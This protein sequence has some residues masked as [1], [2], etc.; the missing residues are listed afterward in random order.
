M[1]GGR[2]RTDQRTQRA[3]H[4]HNAGDVSL[5][6]D[7]DGDT[8]AD[9]VRH[10]VGLQ[11]REGENE[12]RLE[13]QDFRNVR[14]N[15]RRYPRLLA[16]DPRRPYRVAGDANDPILL[17]QKVQRFHSLFGETDDPARRELAHA[18]RMQNYRLVVTAAITSN[19][20]A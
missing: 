17:A 3:Y 8:G 4:R 10:D 16:P 13:L 5:V 2:C 19:V 14:R 9:Q 1:I 7:V 18:K 15:E 11:I 20:I 6:E 12:V